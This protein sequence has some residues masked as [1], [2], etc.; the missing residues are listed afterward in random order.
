MDYTYMT[1]NKSEKISAHTI[2]NWK[3]PDELSVFNMLVAPLDMEHEQ[4]QMRMEEQMLSDSSNIPHYINLLLEHL[5]EDESM[6]VAIAENIKQMQARKTRYSRRVEK[7]KNYL[8]M[9][10]DRYELKK[11]ECPNGTVTR[12]KKQA[13][14]LN[15]IDEGAILLHHPELFDRVDPVLNKQSLKDALLDGEC[16]DGAELIDINYIQVRR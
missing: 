15:V 8:E 12:V 4:H 16:I 3:I 13:S 1:R 14:R 5:A 9:I 10:M 11:F 6:E 2:M 7:I